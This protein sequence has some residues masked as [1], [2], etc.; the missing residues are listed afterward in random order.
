MRAKA[1]RD[2]WDE[3]LKLVKHEMS[4]VV[5]WFKHQKLVWEKR[6]EKSNGAD[7]PGHRI[8]ALK[9]VDLWHRLENHARREFLEKMVVN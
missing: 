8:Y 3:E 9:Q 6:A 5:L 1:R 4:W 7:K 2:R